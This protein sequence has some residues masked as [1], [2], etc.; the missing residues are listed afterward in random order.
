M[1]VSAQPPTLAA[2]SAD[3]AP[4]QIWSPT[5]NTA[6]DPKQ[7]GMAWLLLPD[8]ELVIDQG[9]MI[10]LTGSAGAGKSALLEKIASRARQQWGWMG[11]AGVKLGDS[12]GDE[13]RPLGRCCMTVHSESY[14][15]PRKS[16][17]ENVQLPMKIAGLGGTRWNHRLRAAM[18]RL[19]LPNDDKKMGPMHEL[20]PEFRQRVG[21]ARAL[22][23]DPQLLLVDEAMYSLHDKHKARLLEEI[24]DR[25]RRGGTVIWATR[26]IPAGFEAGAFRWIYLKEAKIVRDE[27]L[28]KEKTDASKVVSISTKSQAQLSSMEQLKA[29]AAAR[30]SAA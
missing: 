22:A 20:H 7:V 9:D 30:K 11:Q 13:Q 12:S 27:R 1:Y 3:A 18:E 6:S 25:V 28:V 14:F 10:M 26:G 24:K 17:I 8:L 16:V 4:T 19:D 29:A 15:D 5:K 21:W 23:C 2:P